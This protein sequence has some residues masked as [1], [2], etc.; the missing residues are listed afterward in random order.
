MT[1]KTEI[2]F[3]KFKETLSSFN[4]TWFFYDI[5]R[6]FCTFFTDNGS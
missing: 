3:I 1:A 4:C 5:N 6:K 2:D